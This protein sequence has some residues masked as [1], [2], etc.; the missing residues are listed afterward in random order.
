M[1]LYKKVSYNNFNI[2]FWSQDDQCDKCFIVLRINTPLKWC[3]ITLGI[4]INILINTFIFRYWPR[5]WFK[6][7][8]SSISRSGMFFNYNNQKCNCILNKKIES[9]LF[10]ANVFEL[11]EKCI[12]Y[13]KRMKQFGKSQIHNVW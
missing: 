13:E 2:I 5:I 12:E 3:K 6:L 4:R 9:A 11:N 1:I 10:T 7:F 8:P